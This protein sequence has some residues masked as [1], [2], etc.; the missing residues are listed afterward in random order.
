[1]IKRGL[2][3][4]PITALLILLGIIALLLLGSNIRLFFSDIEIDQSPLIVSFHI[5]SGKISNDF[6]TKRID[7]VVERGAGEGDLDGI[8]VILEDA[9]GNNYIIKKSDAIGQLES[10][11]FSVD[12]SGSDLNGPV[13][14]V[15]VAPIFIGGNVYSVVAASAI[16]P[17]GPQGSPTPSPTPTPTPSTQ[18]PPSP[19]PL[20]QSS[21]TPSPTPGNVLPGVTLIDPSG[22]I[23]GKTGDQPKFKKWGEGSE[24]IVLL[25]TTPFLDSTPVWVGGN[26]AKA[27]DNKDGGWQAEDISLD[28]T[29][30]YRYTIWMKKIN[31][32]DG[33]LYFGVKPPATDLSTG[34]ASSGAFFWEG[35]LPQI[36]KWYLLVGFIH[37][38]TSSDNPTI[39]GGIYDPVTISM[40]APVLRDL[41]HTDSTRVTESHRAFLGFDANV[42]DRIYLYAPRVEL[43]DG[44]EASINDLLTGTVR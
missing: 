25:Q 24:N 10:K 29:K 16:V 4:I 8:N 1:M 26:D 20:P 17:E 44:S 23:V 2:S 32:Q 42:N 28:T 5:P 33:N 39:T 13:V 19:T 30:L 40:V 31:S 27:T 6:L 36:D 41:R 11:S 15:S 18:P 14:K 37:P 12:Y 38:Y 35:D 22:W 3:S 43:V 34:L 21:S 9:Q 7:F